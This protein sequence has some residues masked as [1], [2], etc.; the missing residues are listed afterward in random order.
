MKGPIPKC[1]NC[2]AWAPLNRDREWGWCA[3]QRVSSESHK[4]TPFGSVIRSRSEVDVETRPNMTC[5]MHVL[6]SEGGE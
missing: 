6:N 1:G 5:P 3:L 2:R 4:E